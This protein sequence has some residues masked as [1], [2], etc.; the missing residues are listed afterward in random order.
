MAFSLFLILLLHCT[1][2]F[3]HHR[4]HLSPD[5]DC[6]WRRVVVTCGIH[7]RDLAHCVSVVSLAVF[8]CSPYLLSMGNLIWRLDSVQ[9]RLFGEN[10]SQLVLCTS[11]RVPSTG[12]WSLVVTHWEADQWLQVAGPSVRKCPS[13]PPKWFGTHWWPLLR[14]L[15]FPP[16]L[17]WTSSAKKAFSSLAVRLLWNA[18]H[19]KRQD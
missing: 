1:P 3:H 10:T 13:A 16:C 19:T 18:V 2:S 6:W 5:T 11:C 8:L 9:T 4:P 17:S 12:R 7:V 14:S 15:L